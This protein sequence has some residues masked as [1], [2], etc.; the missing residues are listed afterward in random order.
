MISQ[1]TTTSFS[2]SNVRNPSMCRFRL[3]KNMCYALGCRLPSNSHH[4]DCY[5]FSR[6]SRTKPSFATGI[7]GGGHIPKL[8]LAKNST[9]LK[10]PVMLKMFLKTCFIVEKKTQ[11]PPMCF[12]ET[13][14]SLSKN[15][16]KYHQM[17]YGLNTSQK[18]ILAIIFLCFFPCFPFL[19]STWQKKNSL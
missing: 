1:K 5:V 2:L 19:C 17:K 7:L 11:N 8:C 18:I 6:G 9:C 12:K 14:L 3:K 15:L 13:D 4:Q 10:I 16:L